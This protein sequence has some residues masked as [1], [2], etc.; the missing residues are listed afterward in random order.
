MPH[1]CPQTASDL[2]QSCE[3]KLEGTNFGSGQCSME[4]HALAA[5]MMR[6]HKT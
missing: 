4:S 2:G 6:N 1:M 3:D 5:G